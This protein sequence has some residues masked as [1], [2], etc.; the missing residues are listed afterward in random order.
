[1]NKPKLE[2]LVGL[3]VVLGFI[4]L[5]L[6]VFFVSGVY[7]FRHGYHV[8][9]VFDYVGIIN[10]GAPVRFAG[11]RV[12]EVQMVKVLPSTEVGKKG[13]VE[14]LFFVE[15]GVQIREN[16]RISIDGNHIMSEPHVAITPTPGDG[17]ILKDDD[18]VQGTS[19]YSTDELLVQLGD[20]ADGLSK[21]IKDAGGVFEDP[22]T[23]KMLG[24][25][26]KNMNQLMTSMNAI[27]SG[28]EK[29][30]RDMVGRMSQTSQEL[31]TFLERMNK[32]QGTLG[33]LV[34]EDEIYNDLR[35]FVKEIKAHPWRLFK[36]D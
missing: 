18:L 20:S 17:R 35:D 16:Y 27:T 15:G 31:N 6:I 8:R 19:A 22:D 12:G 36:K 2:V 24:D 13:N 30:I 26:L 10:R 23:R 9:A 14:I 28:Q 32:G 3:F 5:L 1:M 29:E 4:L 11:V 21:L 25:S 7:F 34:V 33:K